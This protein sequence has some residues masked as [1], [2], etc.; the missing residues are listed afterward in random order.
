MGVLGIQGHLLRLRPRGL[1]PTFFMKPI[2]NVKQH[3]QIIR[4]KK[5]PDRL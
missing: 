4:G 5:N 1:V 3:E 2:N